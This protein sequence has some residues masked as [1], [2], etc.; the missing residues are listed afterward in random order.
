VSHQNAVSLMVKYHF[1]HWLTTAE[2]DYST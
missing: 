1:L 2:V